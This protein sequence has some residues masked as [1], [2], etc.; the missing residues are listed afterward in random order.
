MIT[1]S[2]TQHKSYL[3]VV[4]I[5]P[6][7]KSVETILPGSDPEKLV[8]EARR[9]MY[10]KN[11]DYILQKLT[12]WLNQ[13]IFAFNITYRTSCAMDAAKLILMLGHYQNISF[14][15]LCC[16]VADH[17]PQFEAL[18]P[19]YRYGRHNGHY[20]AWRNKIMPVINFCS[21]I[22]EGTI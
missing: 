15:N 4:F 6:D 14:F 16:L 13:R 5:F 22:K 11:R 10:F 2:L 21:Q 20:N 9:L 3:Q 12:G 8:G 17:R 1:A 7:L 18:A 19:S